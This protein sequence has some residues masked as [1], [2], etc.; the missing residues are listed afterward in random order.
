MN[1]CDEELLTCPRKIKA[2]K[3]FDGDGLY[4]EIPPRGNIRWRYRYTMNGKESRVSLGIYPEVTIETARKLKDETKALIANGINPS[5]ERKRTRFCFKFSKVKMANA[6][7]EAREA[8]V[9]QAIDIIQ[10]CLTN[11]RKTTLLK[12]PTIV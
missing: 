7:L 10:E 3:I 6:T 9:A 4:A 11:I 5:Q 8:Y 12:E 1:L 2:Y